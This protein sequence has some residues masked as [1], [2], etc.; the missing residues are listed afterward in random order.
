MQKLNNENSDKEIYKITV[1]L[2]GVVV[3]LGC[4]YYGFNNSSL[5]ITQQHISYLN[6]WT[7]KSEISLYIGLITSSLSLGCLIGSLLTSQFLIATNY[8]FRLCLMLT[9]VLGIVGIIEQI[10][11]HSFGHFLLGRL[12]AGLACGLNTTII[13]IYLKEFTPMALRG[14]TGTFVQI[15]AQLGSFLC[16]CLGIIQPIYSLDTTVEDKQQFIQELISQQSFFEREIAWRLTLGV[17]ILMCLIR[18]FC[19][20][21]VYNQP[22][23][24]QMAQRN[25]LRALK[26]YL[27]DIYY[28][29]R[30]QACYQAYISHVKE[31]IREVSEHSEIYQQDNLKQSDLFQSQG[32]NKNESMIHQN[33]KG[34]VDFIRTTSLN[35][36]LLASDDLVQTEIYNS[37]SQKKSRKMQRSK[38]RRFMLGLIVQT[39]SRVSGL[40]ALTFYS[41]LIFSEQIKNQ[42]LNY[43]LIVIL[44]LSGFI[45]TYLSFFFIERAG[46]KPLI[47]LSTIL[48]MISQLGIAIFS[49][50]NMFIFSFISIM[51]FLFAF[52]IGQGGV[53]WPYTIELVNQ[54]HVSYCSAMR[55]TWVLI[56][57]VTF[58]F[59]NQLLG[60]SGTFFTYLGATFLCFL[61]FLKELKET[62]GL[63]KEQVESMYY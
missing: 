39:A 33:M 4:L 52:G 40:S 45:F 17:P 46:R 1:Y 21:S 54:E 32:K 48:L 37:F 49:M 19:L 15:F 62:K 7:D 25:Q 9:D 47:L 50:L 3:S 10:I 61:Y 53:T 34:E 42:S 63:T 13:P 22:T 12:L 43:I 56:I 11:D 31:S 55:W 41:S 36:S 2:R 23:P 5:N 38:V 29:N 35:R 24:I 20:Y 59:T 18:I 28:P 57:G 26:L 14:K 16:V 51:F 8:N 58:P 27:S 30:A 6:G 60:L 44:G